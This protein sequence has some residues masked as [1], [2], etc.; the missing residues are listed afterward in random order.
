MQIRIL[1]Q[2]ILIVILSVISAVI[3]NAISAHGISLIYNPPFLSDSHSLSVEEVYSLYVEGRTLF[4]DSRYP[5]EFSQSHIR[6]AINIPVSWPIEK[7]DKT[8][9]QYDKKRMIIVYCSSSQCN[10]SYRLAGILQYIKFENVYI[11]SGGL[12]EWQ[13]KDYPQKNE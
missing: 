7:I 11:F 8:M 1:S 12:E 4:I 3:F 5:E 10:S 13:L 2:I 9:H 6:T